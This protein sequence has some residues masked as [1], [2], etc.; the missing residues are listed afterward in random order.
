M[1]DDPIVSAY[2]EHTRHLVHNVIHGDDPY[3]S[4]L[5]VMGATL[6]FFPA[7]EHAGDVYCLWG[8]LTDWVEVKPHE[9]ALAVGHMVTAAREWLAL[10]HDDDD[11]VRGYLVSWHDL[12]G[13]DGNVSG[14]G[15]N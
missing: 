7:Y 14:G 5:H 15:S 6:D 11:A 1:N 9:K 10:D 4:A 3:D 12:V 13:Y 8:A 2:L